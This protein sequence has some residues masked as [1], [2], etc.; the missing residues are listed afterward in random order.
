MRKPSKELCNSADSDDGVRRFTSCSRW[1]AGT[2]FPQMTLRCRLPLEG[3]VSSITGQRLGKA[4]SSLSPGRRIV[5]QHRCSCGITT[6]VNHFERYSEGS[7]HHRGSGAFFQTSRLIEKDWALLAGR[8]R[9]GPKPSF[10]E[11][12]LDEIPF[13]LEA[14]MPPYLMASDPHCFAGR[15]RPLEHPVNI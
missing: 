3:F 4:G 8:T 9:H 10:F 5:P 6:K 13:I 11:R 1:I 15:P 12:G 14:V 2:S 7:N